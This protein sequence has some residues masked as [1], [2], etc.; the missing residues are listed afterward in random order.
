MK[1][2]PTEVKKK[3]LEA[4]MKG[5]DEALDS[6]P[7]PKK[8]EALVLNLGIGKMPKK[9]MMEEEEESEG[10]MEPKKK[11]RMSALKDLLRSKGD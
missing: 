5:T 11:A 3:L 9:E 1:K 10:D 8:D 4:L 2:I 7:A 6:V